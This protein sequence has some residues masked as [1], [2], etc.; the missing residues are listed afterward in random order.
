V[1]NNNPEMQS[2]DAINSAL[3]AKAS[4]QA[5]A[6]VK[7][8]LEGIM[9]ALALPTYSGDKENHPF[10]WDY[11]EITNSKYDHQYRCGKVSREVYSTFCA[12]LKHLRY[13]MTQERAAFLHAQMVADLL[14]KVSLSI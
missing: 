11:G 4:A 8:V 7:V 6:E 12:G 10:K 14:K 2:T 5:A 1:S 13:A 3:L 9:K